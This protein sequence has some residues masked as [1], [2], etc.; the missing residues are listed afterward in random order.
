MG[1]SGSLPIGFLFAV[2]PFFATSYAFEFSLGPVLLPI[3]WIDGV[4][5]LIQRIIAKK[6]ILTAHKEHL[7]Q[8]VQ[9]VLLTKKQTISVFIFLNLLGGLPY[10]ILQKNSILALGITI[11][12]NLGVYFAIYYLYKKKLNASSIQ[13]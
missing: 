12:I 7:Y 3:F 9:G 10:Y 2:A 5:T 6:N 11:A 13:A 4:F 1:D 8:K